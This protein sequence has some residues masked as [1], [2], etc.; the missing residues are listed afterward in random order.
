MYNLVGGRS[1][2]N[3]SHNCA[4]KFHR[5]KVTKHE[6]IFFAKENITENT[7]YTFGD[8]CAAVGSEPC[9]QDAYARVRKVGQ[10]SRNMTKMCIAKEKIR[11]S[12]WYTFGE[13]HAYVPRVYNK[14]L[15]VNTN[16]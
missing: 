7:W 8:F 13:F 3:A 6:E 1:R 5:S 10:R 2:N 16:I 11:K 9:T 15:E 14:M 4:H 12:V